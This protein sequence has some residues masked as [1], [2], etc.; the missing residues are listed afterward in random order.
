MNP[1]VD[2]NKTKESR[3]VAEP[4][5]LDNR[6]ESTEP[7]SGNQQPYRLPFE[8]GRYR[9]TKVLG[10][11]GMGTVYYAEDTRLGRAVAIKC[12]M[13][14][15]NTAKPTEARFEREAR[16]IAQLEHPGICAVY[17][18]GD[19]NGQPYY[20][21]PY[22][23]GFTLSQWLKSKPKV[24]V[25]Q[26][27]SLFL[28]IVRAVG[29]AHR[30]GIVHRDLKPGNIMLN[31]RGE[32]IVL[33]FGLARDAA[34]DEEALTT[35]GSALGTPA[36]M[37]P[38]QI[39]GSKSQHPIDARTDIYSLGVILY[40]MLTGQLPFSGNNPLEIMAQ[41]LVANP[42]PPSQTS[43]RAVSDLDETVMRCIERTPDN[44]YQKTIEL[45][46]ALVQFLTS[47]TRDES[48]QLNRQN[49][50]Q[51]PIPLD[52]AVRN[53]ISQPASTATSDRLSKSSRRQTPRRYPPSLLIA[54][55][56]A[57]LFALLGV[58]IVIT[59]KDGSKTRIEANDATNVAIQTDADLQIEVI[60]QNP[61]ESPEATPSHSQS[62]SHGI[63][64]DFQYSVDGYTV[65]YLELQEMMLPEGRHLLSVSHSGRKLFQQAFDVDEPNGRI[66]AP[67]IDK[68]LANYFL[69]RKVSSIVTRIGDERLRVVATFEL[70]SIEEFSVVEIDAFRSPEVRDSDLNLVKY[71]PDLEN[72]ILTETSVTDAGI[73]D[74]PSMPKLTGLVLT[75]TRTT[76]PRISAI[77]K[78]MPALHTL[79]CLGIEVDDGFIDSI[80]SRK[81][82]GFLWLTG[83]RITNL[84]AFNIVRGA[85]FPHGKCIGWLTLENTQI[86]DS[87]LEHIC[88]VADNLCLTGAHIT[89]D[90]LTVFSGM[91]LNSLQ[92]ANTAISDEGLRI[93]GNIKAI[94]EL[95]LSG[96]KV[97]DAGIAEFQARFPNCRIHR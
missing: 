22:V 48:I 29:E 42:E 69:S 55:S 18:Y 49:A 77:V 91:S 24:S 59:N 23:D 92:I 71:L 56:A 32:P 16:A 72:L 84:G 85:G 45:E 30:K 60:P 10:Q 19:F 53:L 83:S 97:T 96:T 57:G 28:K 52:E 40:E 61:A 9:L 62:E 5:T 51:N 94:N 90:G 86:D 70:P 17:D 7:N 3:Q 36:Y 35:T 39:Q 41:T 63:H 6:Q 4:D 20:V 79:G 88:G 43:N 33:D 26:L 27:V 87:G 82:S 13:I 66:R 80:A 25:R 76:P 73:D 95:M 74:I 46:Q 44:R 81:W 65:N 89:D 15:Q 11:G 50:S 37:S 58:I 8:L 67:S 78:R 93:L 21:M 31:K 38:E 64:N 68:V 75:G 14:D 1:E 54:V 2:K 34:S 12:P 47:Q